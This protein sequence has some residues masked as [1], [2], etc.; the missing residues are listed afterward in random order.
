MYSSDDPYDFNKVFFPSMI[1]QSPFE[2]VW[3]V[4]EREAVLPLMSWRGHSL[5]FEGLPEH[6]LDFHFTFQCSFFADAS[7]P[8][9]FQLPVWVLPNIRFLKDKTVVCP[10]R[11]ISWEDFIRFHPQLSQSGEHQKSS[12]PRS[13][14]PKDVQGLVEQQLLAEFPWLTDEDLDKALG[15]VKTGHG[16]PSQSAASSSSGTPAAS[17]SSKEAAPTVLDVDLHSLIAE[18]AEIRSL[19]QQPKVDV[20]FFYVH[21]RGGEANLKKPAQG[22]LNNATCFARSI[23]KAVCERYQWPKQKGFQYTAVNGHDN[24]DALAKQWCHLGNHYCSHWFAHDCD[25]HFVFGPEDDPEETL[26]WTDFMA[27]FVDDE[28]MWDYY[29]MP[30]WHPRPI[31]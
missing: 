27:Q 16:K 23:A 28:Y 15:R 4:L 24:A 10:G 3:Q 21:H 5:A 29:C 6:C 1:M 25:P 31:N 7:V 26:E 30:A 20:T 18:A 17:S 14:L 22:I 9:D 2:V 11:P 8:I 19:H 13:S 12:K